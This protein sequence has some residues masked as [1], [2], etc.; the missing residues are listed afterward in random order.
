LRREAAHL[1]STDRLLLARY[2]GEELAVLLPG[3]NLAGA[4]RIAESLRRA[5]ETTPVQFEGKSISI[6]SSVGVAVAPYHGATA[7]ELLTSVDQVLYQAKTEGRNR[8]CVAA[9]N[10][11]ATL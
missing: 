6:T 9:A 10:V 3:I 7:S 8:V 11:P 4:I 1:R 5:I 2:G